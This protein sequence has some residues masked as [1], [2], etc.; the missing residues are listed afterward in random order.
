MKYRQEEN[1]ERLF[2]YKDNPLKLEIEHFV[3]SIKTGKNKFNPNQD[4]ETLKLT[5]KIEELLRQQEETS[6]ASSHRRN[7]NTA[8]CSL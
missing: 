7:R 2:V 5:L 8:T 1:V 6:N 4:I 3:K